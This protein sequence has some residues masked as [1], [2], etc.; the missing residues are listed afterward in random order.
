MTRIKKIK[1]KGGASNDSLKEL[2]VSMENMLYTFQKSINPIL[3][4]IK[5][6][7]SALHYLPR[8]ILSFFFIFFFIFVYLFEL[9]KELGFSRDIFISIKN[10]FKNIPFEVINSFYILFSI[11][12]IFIIFYYSLEYISFL[13]ERS[14][15]GLKNIILSIIVIFISISIN[16]VNLL[17]YIYHQSLFSLFIESIYSDDYKDSKLYDTDMFIQNSVL[18]MAFVFILFI[19]IFYILQIKIHE[20]RN[21]DINISVFLMI[22]II[23]FIFFYLLQLYGLQFIK[24][25]LIEP[26]KNDTDNDCNNANKTFSI[27]IAII[28][29]I[30]GISIVII[31]KNIKMSDQL[32]EN[33]FMLFEKLLDSLSLE[34]EAQVIHSK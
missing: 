10:F 3:F 17:S 28:I 21:P 7:E 34:K 30:I 2:I 24:N 15:Y 8:N 6:Q 33:T 14:G 5:K 13:F 9:F 22:L 1:Q 12:I 11:F 4:N 25:K 20:K 32:N 18:I 29:H 31:Q 23:Y 16:L 27:I 19:F 26:F